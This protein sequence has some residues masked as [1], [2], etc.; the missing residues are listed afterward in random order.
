VVLFTLTARNTDVACHE[1][2][3]HRPGFSRQL[4]AGENAPL[5]ICAFHK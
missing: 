2:R 3:P 4:A 1:D 5:Q